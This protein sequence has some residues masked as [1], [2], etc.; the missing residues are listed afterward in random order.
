MSAASGRPLRGAEYLRVRFGRG[1]PVV[2]AIVQRMMRRNVVSVRPDSLDRLAAL[3]GVSRDQLSAYQTELGSDPLVDHLTQA[4]AGLPY[5]GEIPQGALLY[6]FVRAVRP[7]KFV[8]TGVAAGFSSAFLLAALRRNQ[9]GRLYSIDIGDAPGKT[10]ETHFGVGWL[11]PPYLRDRWDLRI[12]RSQELLEPLL[13]EVGPVDVFLHDSL[14]SYDHMKFEF[15]TA[16]PHVR[17]GGYFLAHDVQMTP[18]WAELCRAHG[19]AEF[20]VFDP[21]PPPVG[22][23]RVPWVSFR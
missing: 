20:P 19:M 4:R 12:G 11:V 10:K 17:P 2:S 5:M 6:V 21:G 15:N 9:T 13:N 8:E 22:A 16:W 23:V 3:T 18:A 14:H 1:V 7:E